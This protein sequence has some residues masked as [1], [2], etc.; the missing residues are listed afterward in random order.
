MAGATG[1]LRARPMGSPRVMPAAAIVGVGRRFIRVEEHV[2]LRWTC[3]AEVDANTRQAPGCPRAG[4]QVNLHLPLLRAIFRKRL[5]N[6]R[7]LESG[8][9]STADRNL[10]MDIVVWGGG[11]R[12]A[13]DRS[14]EV[15]PHCWMFAIHTHKGRYT[16]EEA[17]MTT[18]NQLPLHPRR[19][20]IGPTL[21]RHMCHSTNGASGGKLWAPRGR[22][23]T[24]RQK[25][26]W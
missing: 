26:W 5:G 12:D 9:P 10:R 4:E 21:V 7:R 14:T 17:V 23:S 15:N 24:S 25:A 18:M 3:Y 16:C 13:P 22:N 20:I 2:A 1:C 6:V 11:L 8:Q 19:T